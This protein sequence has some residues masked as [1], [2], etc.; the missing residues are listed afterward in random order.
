VSH[1]TDWK[2]YDSVATDYE[3]LTPVLFGRLADDLVD[4]IAPTESARVLDA[5]IGTGTAAAAVASRLGAAGC[6]VGVDPSLGMLAVARER[7]TV[8]AGALPG[9]P[10]RDASFD[11]ALANLVLSH[12]PEL[13]EGAADIVR[14]VRPGGR[15]GVTAW[16]EDGPSRAS[17]AKEA[18]ELLDSTLA[19]VG[20][21]VEVPKS[22]R[23][24]PAEDWLRDEDNLGTTLTDAG[25]TDVRMEVHE[26]KYK[27]TAGDYLGWH[28]W[29][30]R[31]RYLRSLGESAKLGEF[32][33]HARAGLEE[34]F[35]DAIRM[36]SHARLA[37]GTKAG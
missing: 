8:V 12:L 22:E 19:D 23:M 24:A 31:G 9:L 30:G 16:P 3:R 28:A 26:Y 14:A 25:L 15:V 7:A 34:R 33:R 4:L 32:E 27:L 1:P 36:V 37:V 17:D 35:P 21:P 10:F 29:A 5:G 20:L 2:S 11:F 13:Q 18:M 6:V